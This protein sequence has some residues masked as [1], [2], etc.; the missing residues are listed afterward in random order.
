[1]QVEGLLLV[2][3]GHVCGCS[4]PRTTPACSTV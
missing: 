1:M 3:A 2:V 4:R